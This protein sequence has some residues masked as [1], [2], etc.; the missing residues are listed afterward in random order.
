MRR[1]TTRLGGRY[2]RK[3]E[4]STFFGGSGFS[5]AV[6]AADFVSYLDFAGLCI[7]SSLRETVLSKRNLV[8]AKTQ[9]RKVNRKVRPYLAAQIADFAD[10]RDQ[11]VI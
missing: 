5:P 10:G 8:H 4:S 2:T 9:S 11:N 7:L 3:S 6:M 1:S